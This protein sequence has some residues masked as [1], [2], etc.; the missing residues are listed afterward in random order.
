MKVITS[1]NVSLP[2]HAD[3]IVTADGHYAVSSAFVRSANEPFVCI[4]LSMLPIDMQ[5]HVVSTV[6]DEA[7]AMIADDWLIKQ[8]A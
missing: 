8:S 7:A 2:I 6:V 5:K 4:P 1:V 3:V